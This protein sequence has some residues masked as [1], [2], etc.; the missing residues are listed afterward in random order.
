[1]LKRSPCFAMAALFC[2]TAG[3]AAQA[4]HRPQPAPP[5]DA[6]PLQIAQPTQPVAP[7]GPCRFRYSGRWFG[8]AGV[9][10]EIRQEGSRISWSAPDFNEE[11]TGGCEGSV[12]RA[13]WNGD[14]GSGNAQGRTSGTPSGDAVLITWSNG[15]TFWRVPAM[16]V[17]SD[18]D[19]V[20]RG[21]TVEFVAEILP[22]DIPDRRYFITFGDGAEEFYE[23]HPTRHVYGSAGQFDVVLTTVV[24]DRRFTSPPF[25]I[26]VSEPTPSPQPPLE[27]GLRL[28]IDR[29]AAR[30]GEP[31]RLWAILT[32]ETPGA[33]YQFSFAGQT[34]PW[35]AQPEYRLR[36]RSEG[37]WEAH[38]TARLPGPDVRFIDSPFLAVTV[39]ALSTPAVSPSGDAFSPL[40]LVPPALLLG[41]AWVYR[42]ARRRKRAREQEE[43]R[44]RVQYERRMDL[45]R[46]S[47]TPEPAQLCRTELLFRLVGD[48][49]RQ[50]VEGLSV[51][52]ERR[53]P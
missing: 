26:Q 23:G 42:S 7:S 22:P 4:A 5:P 2:L 35:L 40:W 18:R 36:C 8:S 44:R 14:L 13:Q 41:G 27:P 47:M 28:G 45:G 50:Q 48:K 21:E 39:Q 52:G 29:R 51:T 34:S 16:T 17:R 33:I 3:V 20:I 30:V 9:V 10:Y 38:V 24:N 1:M 25:R 15:V 46:Q 12:V 43:M 37:V 19:S 32:P 49:G 11:A 31:V 53:E 6:F